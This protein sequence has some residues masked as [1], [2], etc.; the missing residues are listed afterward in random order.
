MPFAVESEQMIG[1]DA[2][3]MLPCRHKHMQPH[4]TKG[5]L[6]NVLHI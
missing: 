4:S 6:D 1:S 3:I 5:K 2:I